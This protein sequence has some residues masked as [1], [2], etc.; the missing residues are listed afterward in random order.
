MER[1]LGTQRYDIIAEAIAN[2]R[3]ATLGV[4]MARY[5]A[6]Q[7]ANSEPVS[8]GAFLLYL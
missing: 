8:Y 4:L 2:G 5:D 6:K 7:R 3:Q 1:I